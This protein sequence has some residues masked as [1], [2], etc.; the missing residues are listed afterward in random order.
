M[1]KYGNL[2]IQQFIF[3]LNLKAIMPKR[4]VL[5]KVPTWPLRFFTQRNALSRMTVE[6]EHFLTRKL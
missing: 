2:K 5:A 3:I 1:T 6:V 4:M